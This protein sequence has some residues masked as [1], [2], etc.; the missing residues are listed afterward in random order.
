MLIVSVWKK[1]F[2]F[3]T[4]QTHN[5]NKS[6]FYFRYVDDILASFDQ[7]QD[8]LIFLNCLNKRHPNIKS[9][10]EKQINRSIAFVD[11][12]I[13]GTSNRNLTLKIYHKS[14]YTDRLN[15]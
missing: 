3:G 5:L 12:F 11:V 7:E 15:F 13:S 10:I 14:T 6:K 2:V 4:S 9:T 1:L 8:S